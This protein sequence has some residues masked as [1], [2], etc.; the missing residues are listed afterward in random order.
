MAKIQVFSKII[1][2]LFK[3][4]CNIASLS[5]ITPTNKGKTSLDIIQL[6][7]YFLQYKLLIIYST[8]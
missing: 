4:I 7:K 2:L 6:N 3:I 1:T 5:S 8:I